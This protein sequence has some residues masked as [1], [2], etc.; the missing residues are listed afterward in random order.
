MP[1]LRRLGAGTPVEVLVPYGAFLVSQGGG[2][3][4]SAVGA[5]TLTFGGGLVAAIDQLETASALS[6]ITKVDSLVVDVDSNGTVEPGDTLRY[7]ITIP[8]SATAAGVILT[9][10]PDANTT[11]VAGSVTNTSAGSPFG[12][13]T[14]GNTAGD[15]N[16]TVNLGTLSNSA[17]IVTFDVVVNSPFSGTSPVCNR[18][19][20]SATGLSPVVSDDPDDPTGSDDP[21]C[22]RV[23]LDLEPPVLTVPTDTTVA[24]GTDTSPDT[25]GHASAT[26]NVTAEP[27]I[28]FSDTESLGPIPF[29]SVITRTWTATDEAGNSSQGQ[30]KI[31]LADTVARGLAVSQSTYGLFSPLSSSG[32]RQLGTIDT[33]GNV[34]LLGTDTSLD[35]GDISTGAGFTT[36]DRVTKTVYALG[37]TASD[38]LSR[39]FAVNATDGSST[40]SVLSL[41]SIS[42]VVGIWWDEVS[43]TLFGVFQVGAGLS[44]RQLGSINP[45]NGVVTL[46]G[47][48]QSTIAGTIGG[49]LTGSRSD[50]E[51]YFLGTS[52]GLPG[53]V[54]TVDLSTGAMTNA[55]LSG[56]NYNAVAGMN[57]NQSDGTLY[58]L[59]FQGAERRLAELH[60]QTGTV[61]LLGTNTVAGGGVS[62]ATYTGVNTLDE[63]SGTFLFIGRY[64]DGTNDVWA[65]FGVDIATGDTTFSGVDNSSLTANGY[66]GLDYEEPKDLT[67][68]A[69]GFLGTDFYIDVTQGTAYLKVTSSDDLVLP[70][71][72]VAGVTEANDGNAQPNRFLIPEYSR[73]SERDFFRV[74]PE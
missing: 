46:I 32:R 36:F 22:T 48:P 68:V 41:G 8:A 24:R 58:A 12:T 25:A 35:A 15:T 69:V 18:A 9:D 33:D 13:V 7:T 26:D 30:Q 5:I 38:D 59:T 3:I 44:D 66:Y 74:E 51:V 40:N 11:L 50:G 21:T 47:S 52:G 63:D 54:Y 62:I 49:I 37:K 29:Q 65:I 27:L 28:S 60:P 19:T 55:P 20:V 17:V 72:D 42:T 1:V 4:F 57:F 16:V 31:T 64:N 6:G 39:I 67:I 43:S 14:E 23:L 56:A 73:G 45:T 70:F 71:T 61:T 10:T 34:G 53:A 2:A